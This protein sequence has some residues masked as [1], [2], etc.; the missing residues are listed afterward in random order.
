MTCCNH[1]CNQGRDCPN[2]LKEK[3]HIIT[4]I[5]LSLVLLALVIFVGVYR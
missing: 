2:R 1:D 3:H 5:V 4:E